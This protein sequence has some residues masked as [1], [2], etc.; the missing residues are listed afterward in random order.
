M[1]NEKNS[2]SFCFQTIFLIGWSSQRQ[3]SHHLHARKN[4]SLQVYLFG[5]RLTDNVTAVKWLFN[6]SLALSLPNTISQSKK[7]FELK[8][9]RYCYTDIQLPCD[10]I[11]LQMFSDENNRATTSRNIRLLMF[12]CYQ[13]KAFW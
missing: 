12:K 10:E 2:I 8:V 6:K 5:C 11:I 9:I 13:Y 1:M 3:Y 4:L 7:M